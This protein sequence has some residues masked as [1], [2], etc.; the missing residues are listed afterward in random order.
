MLSEK[1]VLDL[2]INGNGRTVNDLL[3]EYGV[4]LGLVDRLG[5]LGVGLCDVVVENK[6]SVTLKSSK[7]DDCSVLISLGDTGVGDAFLIRSF[8]VNDDF[9]HEEAFDVNGF[10]VYST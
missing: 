1:E 10:L 8:R 4:S 2:I 9:I 5:N 7:V 6:N 3:D